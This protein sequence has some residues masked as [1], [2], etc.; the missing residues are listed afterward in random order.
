M[1]IN[2]FPHKFRL[3]HLMLTDRQYR[4]AST[5]LVF[6]GYDQGVF[7]NVIISQNFLETHGYPSAEMQGTM[8]SLYNIGCF[9]GKS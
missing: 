2:V 7:G 9:I 5:V 1:D 6:Y 8:T 4:A 3:E